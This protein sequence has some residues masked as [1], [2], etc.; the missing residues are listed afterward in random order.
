LERASGYELSHGEAVALGLIVECELAEQL[1]IASPGLRNRVA[2]LLGR[3]GLPARLPPIDR[4]TLLGNMTIDKKNRRGQVHFA[5]PR[6]MGEMHQEKGWTT[7]VKV[8]AIGAAIA[9]LE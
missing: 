7:P 4:S 2:T 3:F 1:G 6:Q 9:A 5:L 8:E